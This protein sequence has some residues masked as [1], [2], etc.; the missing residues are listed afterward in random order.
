MATFAAVNKINKNMMKR[1]TI[2]R[3]SAAAPLLFAAL[4]LGACSHKQEATATDNEFETVTVKRQSI[5]LSSRYSAS[6]KGKQDVE[7]RPQVSGTIT[8]I[9]V[10]EGAVVHKGQPLFIIDQ[11]PYQAALETAE[12]NVKVAEA[13]VATADMTAKART[14]FTTRKSSPISTAR[15]PPTHSAAT[16]PSSNW[17]VPN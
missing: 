10:S 17:H 15:R 11:V 6:L 4:M 5:N 14:I 9:C 13:N 7:I 1:K 8:Q 16:L 12:A 3:L 2:I